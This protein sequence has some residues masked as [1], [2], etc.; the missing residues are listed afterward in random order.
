MYNTKS[1][2]HWYQ[3]YWFCSQKITIFCTLISDQLRAKKGIGRVLFCLVS[4]DLTCWNKMAN[5]MDFMA[6]LIRI[7]CAKTMG[8]FCLKSEQYNPPYCSL[9]SPEQFGMLI[10][11]YGMIV[12][13]WIIKNSYFK[14]YWLV[15]LVKGKYFVVVHFIKINIFLNKETPRHTK[16]MKEND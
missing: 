15:R 12:R 3:L 6:R 4:I 5:N 11:S 9:F 10:R 1:I 2:N 16:S 7:R 13:D 14:K 8:L